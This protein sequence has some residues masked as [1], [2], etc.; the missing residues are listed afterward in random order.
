LGHASHDNRPNS[1]QLIDPIGYQFPRATGM[2]NAPTHGRY[3]RIGNGEES[4]TFY[5]SIINKTIAKG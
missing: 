3:N 2:G 4:P 5:K 1:Q